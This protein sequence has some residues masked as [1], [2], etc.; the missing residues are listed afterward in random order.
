MA[1]EVADAAIDFWLGSA[2]DEPRL[3]LSFYG[4]EPF[5]EPELMRRATGRARRLARGGQSVRCMTPTNGLL[6]DPAAL[7]DELELA[8][9]IDAVGEASE[10]RH[11]DGR[12]PTP[13][14]L[15]ALPTLLPHAKLAR[16]TVTPG[17]VGRLCENV[18]A[19]ARLGFRSIVFQPAWELEWDTS[20]I[21]HWSR[22]H[23]RLTTWMRG[24]RQ[25]GL[26][27][28]E[29][30]TLGGILGRL[31]RGAPRRPCGSGVSL[32]AV[33]TDGSIF[34]C[35]R[36]VFGTDYRLGDVD[37]GITAGEARR[38]LGALD[39]DDLRP[40]DGACARCEA[41]DG[42]THFCPAL[43]YQ[44]CGDL[45]AVPA[46]VCELMRAAVLATRAVLC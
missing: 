45:R 35:Y 32:C 46:A 4:G 43:G 24:A 40:E 34:P 18:R 27:L 28:P 38:E 2:G 41:R 25:A 3:D 26:A 6:A 31:R 20:A 14:L 44:R 22:E 10:R 1:E 12:N 21:R 7:G 30:P 17:N 16:M 29:L 9:S 36:F 13:A 8:V 39:P 5:L 15:A 11:A 42:C 33:A 23:G 19:I 37:R